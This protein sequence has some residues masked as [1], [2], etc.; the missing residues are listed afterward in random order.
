MRL[1]EDSILTYAFCRALPSPTLEVRRRQAS[2]SNNNRRSSSSSSTLLKA[3]KVDSSMALRLALLPSNKVRANLR[4]ALPHL[5]HPKTS[6]NTCA[7]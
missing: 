6:D 1:F 2:S 5:P 3:S 7:S 4:V